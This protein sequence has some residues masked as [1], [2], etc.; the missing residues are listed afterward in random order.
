MTEALPSAPDAVLV[1]YGE[2]ALK[3]GNR[4]MFERALVQ[5]IRRALKP[6]ARARVELRQGR[7]AIFPEGRTRQVARR[8]QDVFGIKTVSPAWRVPTE[9]EPILAMAGR[10]LDDAMASRPTDRPTTFRV[11]TRRADKRFPHT[12]TEFDC[13]VADHILPDPVA[14]NVR[15]QLKDP[16]LELGIELRDRETWL[17]CE[18][19]PGHGGLP[20][21]TL[22]RVLTLLSGGIDSPVAAWMA[23]K[24]GCRVSYITY[25]SYPYI[26]EP[27]KKKVLDLARS[28]ARWQQRARLYVTPFTEVQETIRDS[29]PEGYRTVLYRRMMQRIAAVVSR[30]DGYAALV[31][32]ESM[33]QVASQTL[34]NMTC[35]GAAS[36]MPVLRPLVAFDKEETIDIARKIGTFDLSAIPEPDCCTVF[37]PKSPVI[38][39][40][41]EECLAAEAQ[42]DVEGLVQRAIEG[43]EVITVEE[44]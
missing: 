41:L 36:S 37:Q 34:E 18:R 10:V 40:R 30:R 16:E 25:H 3:G 21:G 33:G 1:R 5:N 26:G 32:G 8:V 24:R 20:V 29:A 2:L 23:M 38:H 13:M 14:R 42:F 19:L 6:I 31:T 12:S 28:L 27:S 22:G 4:G 43:L 11:R 9:V 7:I 35:I 39:G 15:I 17:F 44:E